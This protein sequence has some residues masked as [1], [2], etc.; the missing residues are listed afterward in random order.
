MDPDSGSRPTKTI[1]AVG[2]GREHAPGLSVCHYG[3]SVCNLVCL[4]S[5]TTGRAKKVP[6]AT[7]YRDG[8]YNLFVTLPSRRGFHNQLIIFAPFFL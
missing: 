4:R 8:H 1:S 7:A 3:L 5:F 2:K 6:D